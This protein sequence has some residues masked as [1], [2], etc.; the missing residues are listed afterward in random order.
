MT[1]AQD[2]NEWVRQRGEFRVTWR[3]YDRAEVEKVPAGSAKR[4]SYGDRRNETPWPKTS[5]ASPPNWRRCAPSLKL[6]ERLVACAG[7]R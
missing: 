3:G 6:Q 5:A 1:S 7:Y 2:R 4:P